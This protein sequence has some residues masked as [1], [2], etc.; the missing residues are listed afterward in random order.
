M[1][2]AVTP[3]QASP[4]AAVSGVDLSKPLDPATKDAL[5][6]ALAEHL[7]LVFHDQSLTPDQYLAAAAVFGP[8]MRQHYGQ[9]NMPDHLAPQRPA[10]GGAL[11][12]RSHEP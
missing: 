10:A 9:H 7:A 8:P 12:Y 11:A 2:I 1:P 4:G 3:F 6:A 5:T